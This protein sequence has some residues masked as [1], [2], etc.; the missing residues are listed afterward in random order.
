MGVFGRR[1]GRWEFD[2]FSLGG[3]IDRIK[4][5]NLY[6]NIISYFVLL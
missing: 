1:L 2:R 3:C 4:F 6:D 5:K